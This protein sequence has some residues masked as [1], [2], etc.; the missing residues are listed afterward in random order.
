MLKP[1]KKRDD[2][3]AWCQDNDDIEIVRAYLGA[4]D[5]MIALHPD[6]PR[7]MWNQAVSLRNYFET[8]ITAFRE[9][10]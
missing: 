1:D 7:R 10:K 9:N 8:K 6:G 2:F 3:L 4:L 5:C